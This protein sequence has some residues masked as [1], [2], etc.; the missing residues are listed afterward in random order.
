M[1]A[2]LAPSSL[3]SATQCF[4]DGVYAPCGPGND[5]CTP[6][7]DQATRPVFHVMDKTC[8]E[9]DPNF[10]FYDPVHGMYHLMYQDHVVIPAGGVGGG[11]DIGHVVSRDFVHWAHL[12]VSIWNDKP[13]DRVAIF[14]GSATVV[15]GKPFLVYPGLCKKGG[16]FAGCFTGTNFAQAVPADPTDPFYTNWTKDKAPGVDIAVNPIVNGTSDDPSTAWRTASGEWRLVGN[17]EAKGQKDG[18]KAPI[19]AAKEFTGEWALVGDSPLPGGECQSLYPL[20][21]LYPGTAAGDGP[22]PTH[23]HKWG[24]GPNSCGGDCMNCG[25]WLDGAPGEVGN[26]SATP[27][28]PFEP[29]VIDQGSYYASKDFYDPVKQRRINWGWATIGGGAQSMARV[30]TWHAPLKQLVFSPAP[31]YEQLHGAAPLAKLGATSLTK[32]APLSLADGWEDGVGNASDITI[33]FARPTEACTVGVSVMSGALTVYLNFGKPTVAGTASVAVGLQD[34]P[35]ASAPPPPAGTTGNGTCGGTDFGGDCDSQPKGAWDAAAENITTLAACVAKATPCKMAKFVSFSSVEGNHDC[36]WYSQ[37]DFTRL[38][39]DCSKCGIGCPKYFP[40]E[41]EVLPSSSS[42][43]SSSAAAVEGRQA[44]PPRESARR[45]DTVE[46]RL[47]GGEG[48]EGGEGAWRRVGARGSRQDTLRLL[49]G[50]DEVELRVF[51]DRT[52]VEAYWMDGRVAMTSAIN[53][54]MAVAGAPQA[55]LFSDTDGVQVKSAVAYS[56]G[57]IWVSKEEVLQTP[58]ADSKAA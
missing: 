36:S 17:A 2:C 58:R 15:D 27:G 57:S 28:V 39:E 19:F 56:M 38:C 24:N 30:V 4:K 46:S 14:T 5:Q 34:G 31:E 42:S 23:C 29:V 18:T 8:A 47:E 6:P 3:S 10:P 41:S 53:P 22:L 13:Y 43:S 52:L 25:T 26:W 7:K 44:A 32:Y 51:T 49:P 11:P 1:L 48:G 35:P 40:Y 54:G 9:N 55:F 33:T 16:E 45:L 20:P 21:A 37:C 12:P 50:D